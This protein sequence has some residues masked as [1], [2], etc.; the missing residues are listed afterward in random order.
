[1]SAFRRVL[2]GPVRRSFGIDLS[3]DDMGSII[4]FVGS[5]K[6]R[7]VRGQVA[8][9]DHSLMRKKRIFVHSRVH[10]LVRGNGCGY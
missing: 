3:E 2:V 8:G 4:K 6:E 5:H 1:M 9:F 10:R 7:V